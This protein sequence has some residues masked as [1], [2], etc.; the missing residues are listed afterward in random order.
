VG[1]VGTTEA[2]LEHSQKVMNSR[3]GTT[4]TTIS[5][6]EERDIV[7]LQPH[8]EGEPNNVS[9]SF[10]PKSGSAS[11]SGLLIVKDPW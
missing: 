4:H 7:N 10:Q 5:L 2:L 11:K 9:L 8:A 1:T 3:R 6:E